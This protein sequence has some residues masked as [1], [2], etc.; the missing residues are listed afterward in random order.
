MREGARA[1]TPTPPMCRRGSGGD[2]D[3]PALGLKWELRSCEGDKGVG[4]PSSQLCTHI[5]QA[6][7]PP[8]TP[9]PAPGL[10]ADAVSHRQPLASKPPAVPQWGHRAPGRFWSPSLPPWHQRGSAMAPSAHPSP[11]GAETPGK[12][13]GSNPGKAG[14]CKERAVPPLSAKNRGGFASLEDGERSALPQNLPPAP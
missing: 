6:Q 9:C 1:A 3:G 4:T 14:F 2:T 10:P 11:P 12:S 13:A 7:I 5:W 8:G